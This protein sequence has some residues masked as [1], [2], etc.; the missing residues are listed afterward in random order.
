[1]RDS[2]KTKETILE[3]AK[4]EFWIK[5]YS[6]VSLRTI[7][8][9]ADVDVALI[10]R[11]FENKLGL[12]R[13][14]L[15]D[16]FYWPEADEFSP[17]ELIEGAIHEMVYETDQDDQVTVIRMMQMNAVDPKVGDL[18]IETY[19]NDF[20]NENMKRMKGYVSEESAGL[21]TAVFIGLSQVRKIYKLPVFTNM[22]KDELAAALRHMINAAIGFR[23]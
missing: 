13:A 15:H 6:N 2:H 17:E 18:V 1:M 22:S 5:G 9:S 19:F 12:F 8:K 23:K 16:A 11:Y 4:A 7:A 20:Y 21:I 14:T 10:G 3:T